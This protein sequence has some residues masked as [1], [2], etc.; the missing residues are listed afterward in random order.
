MLDITGDV[1]GHPLLVR[2]AYNTIVPNPGRFIGHWADVTPLVTPG[3][4]QVLTL[5]LSGK[6]PNVPQGVFFENVETILTGELVG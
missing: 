6:S 5:R 1:D 3:K 4:Q 2:K